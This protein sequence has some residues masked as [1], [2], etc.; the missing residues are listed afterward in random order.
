[1]KTAFMYP[2]QGTQ[3]FQMCRDLLDREPAF[4]E[5]MLETDQI[6]QG[7]TGRSV[8]GTIYAP[9]ARMSDVFDRLLMTSPAIFMIE[10]ALTRLL[11]ERGVTPDVVLGASL[12]TFAAATTAGM[13]HVE[14]ALTC[15]VRMAQVVEAHCE[16]GAM[17]AVL[18]PASL[19]R[20]TC[21]ADISTIASVN[22]S[23]HFVVSCSV[24]DLDLVEAALRSH[25]VAFQRLPVR[26]A[27]HSPDIDTAR[28]PL[29]RVLAPLRCRPSRIPLACCAQGRLTTIV[30]LDD[31]WNVVRS[32]ILFSQTIA[33]LEA[34]GAWRYLDVGPTD[35]LATFLK[36][37]LSPGSASR[38]QGLVSPYRR[39]AEFPAS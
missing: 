21:L 17:L 27:F 9:Q 12:G 36:Y 20:T 11:E 29:R 3:Y 19:Y 24:R 2:G 14:D 4:R 38:I 35:T 10:V 32:P 39:G 16:E 26:F 23:E 30:S 31:L 25:A 15:V 33:M 34:R 18:A 7:L 28:E 5:R 37:I 22:Y 13:L 8:I 1:M 6:V